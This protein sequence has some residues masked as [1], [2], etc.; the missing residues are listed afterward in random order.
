MYL[1]KHAT[2]D[3]PRP[4]AVMLNTVQD[5]LLVIVIV[6]Q[7]MSRIFDSRQARKSLL[8]TIDERKTALLEKKKT[9]LGK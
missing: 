6:F 2:P 7:T 4:A 3:R 5:P 1:E 9:V 8:E